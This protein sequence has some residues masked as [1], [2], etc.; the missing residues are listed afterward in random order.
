MSIDYTLFAFP[1]NSRIKDKKL[2]KDKKGNCQ[3]CKKKN[4]YTE[5]HHIKTKGS[6]GDDVE[7]NTI[8][9]CWDCHYKK[10]H[11]GKVSKTELMKA[12]RK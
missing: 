3:L 11:T 2:L 12:K 9:L 1:K 10:V 5:K 6:G 7:D 4:V 8:E